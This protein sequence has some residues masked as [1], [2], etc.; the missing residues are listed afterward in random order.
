MRATAT[1]AMGSMGSAAREASSDIFMRSF[2]ARSGAGDGRARSFAGVRCEVRGGARASAVST[3]R[4]VRELT[5]SAR[6]ATSE[7]RRDARDGVRGDACDVLRARE[8][9]GEARATR[10][11]ALDTNAC[12]DGCVGEDDAAVIVD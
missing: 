9:W 6:D 11:G 3:G 1:P 7:A 5:A 10:A 4:C 8:R 2:R 12:R